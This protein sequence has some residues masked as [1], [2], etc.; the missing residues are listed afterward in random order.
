[1]VPARVRR[2]LRR[3]RRGPGRARRRDRTGVDRGGPGEPQRT[4]AQ[5]TRD[6]D[7]AGA[8]PPRARPD[9]RHRRARERV[10]GRPHRPSRRELPDQRGDAGQ[11][12][13]LRH[14]A[15]HRETG[16]GHREP[17]RRRAARDPGR[18]D[19][20]RVRGDPRRRPA[21]PVRRRPHPG[22]RRHVDQHERQRGRRQPRAGAPR[23]TPGRLPV[24]APARAREPWAEHQ[25]RLPDRDQAR[26]GQPHPGPARRARHAARGLRRRRP[27]SSRTSSRSAAPSCRTPCP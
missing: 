22:W 21:R 27:P 24:A 3:R 10:L 5:M 2:A 7:G 1:M 15:G 12:T 23:P 9:R 8:D 20:G 11:P 16:R 17:R 6:T 19:R 4:E 18:R 26:P 13:L 25:R 14:R